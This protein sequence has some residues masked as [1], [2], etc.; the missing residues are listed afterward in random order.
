[1]RET[2][3]S[4]DVALVR[5]VLEGDAPA[6][7]EIVERLACVSAM[8]RSLNVE[9]GARLSEHDVDDVVQDALSALWSKLASFEGRSRLESWAYR[10]TTNEVLKALER[11]RRAPQ[12]SEV[13]P[14]AHS[15]EVD[16]DRAPIGGSQVVACLARLADDHAVVLR[17]KHFDDL[18]FDEIALRL[19]SPPNTIKARYYR[20]LARLRE[21]L[22]PCMR[23]E[24]A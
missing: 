11:R 12:R 16:E 15:A 14:E 6:R 1:M 22:L 10:F 24:L 5:R 21:A 19:G 7:D 4:Q 17:L 3:W 13:D 18:T 20:G 9:R 8:A 23:R 2:A